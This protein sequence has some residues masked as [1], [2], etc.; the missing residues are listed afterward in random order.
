[1]P[2]VLKWAIVAV[3]ATTALTGVILPALLVPQ[4]AAGDALAPD[5]APA[6]GVAQENCTDDVEI[7][8]DSVYGLVDTDDIYYQLKDPPDYEAGASIWIYFDITNHSC[9]DVSVTVGMTGSVSGATIHTTDL[10]DSGACFSGCDIAAGE[11]FDK[12][13]VGWDLSKHPN[14]D[15]EKVVAV[16][17]VTSPAGFTD[18]D[19]SNNI[20]TSAQYINIVNDPPYEPPAT[21]TPTPTPTNTPTPTPTPTPTHTPTPTNTPTATP[22]PT[23]THTPTPTNTP[24]PTPTITPTPTHTP[25]PTPTATPTP[26]PTN[27]PTPTPTFTPTPTPTNTPTP[28]PLPTVELAIGS[29]APKAGVVGET[30][31]LPANIAVDGQAGAFDGLVA[32]L[33]VG[34][35]GCTLPA[36][37]AEPEANGAVS[38]AWDTSGQTEG[39]HPLQLFAVFPGPSETDAPRLLD[40]ATHKIVLASADGTVFVLMGTND[41]TKGKIVGQVTTPQP[42]IDTPAIYPTATPTPTPTATPT[43]TAT[44]TPTPTATPVPTATPTITPSPTPTATPSPTP[45]PTA[46]PTPTPTSTPTATPTPTPSPTPTP[47]PIPPHDIEIAPD[48]GSPDL[49]VTGESVP[50]KANVGNMGETEALM[51][52]QLYRAGGGDYEMLTDIPDVAV[53]PG[54]TREV[55]LPWDATAENPGPHQLRLSAARAIASYPRRTL[56]R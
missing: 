34:V 42:V 53:G 10:D 7:Y 50:I 29:K 23:P 52:V 41:P 27:T 38:L 55:E 47:T 37:T 56:S 44:P 22:T 26:T 51:R 15:K 40:D 45:T 5:G 1:M 2:A 16:V 14:A 9:Q 11:T 35:S 48:P 25:T 19:P 31:T 20:I 49:W 4:P 6:A 13:N 24:T 32:W 46:T 39:E 43:A 28:T 18:V 21:P 17:T 33:C 30:V 36:A 12:G 3:G 54:A 8:I